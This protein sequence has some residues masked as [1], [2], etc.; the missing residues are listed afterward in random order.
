MDMLHSIHLGTSHL[1]A[2]HRGSGKTNLALT[3]VLNQARYH[4]Y[5]CHE[6]GGHAIPRQ[7]ETAPKVQCFYAV[8]GQPASE[9]DRIV[10]KLE[11]GGALRYTTVIA[12][13]DKDGP[14]LQYLAPHAAAAMAAHIRDSGG[15]ALLVIDGISQYTMAHRDVSL[16][17]GRPM[18]RGK[19]GQLPVDYVTSQASLLEHACALKDRSKLSEGYHKGSFTLLALTDAVR[20]AGFDAASSNLSTAM[21]ST[22]WLNE[23]LAGELSSYHPDISSLNWR[24]FVNGPK[25]VNYHA[26]QGFRYNLWTELDINWMQSLTAASRA[27]M[28]DSFSEIDLCLLDKSD[29]IFAMLRQSALTPISASAQAIVAFCLCN[30]SLIDVSDR[31]LTSYRQKV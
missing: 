7:S 19:K 25:Y 18:V 8:I 6:N 13:T 20:S 5:E 27:V 17:L 2:G 28:K 23:G 15:D 9:V 12:A 10:T 11:A 24:K 3:T 29:R 21:D 14:A 31:R 26:R 16:L 30:T 4:N 1:I 22:V